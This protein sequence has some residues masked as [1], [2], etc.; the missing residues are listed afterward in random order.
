M[1]D[2]DDE[3]TDAELLAATG[4][5]DRTALEGL[6]VRHAPW[7]LVRLS[8]RCADRQ[9][10]DEV[11]QDTFVAVWRGARRWRC[12]GWPG[13]VAPGS[14]RVRPGGVAAGGGEVAQR[15][16]TVCDSGRGA[17]CQ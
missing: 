2:H 3:R 17:S 14:T 1:F 7:L 6:Y 9:L 15:S 10:V 13:G 4:D 8:R 12:E 11:V 5:G 16:F